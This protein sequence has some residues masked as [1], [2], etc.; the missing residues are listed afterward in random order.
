ML[1]GLRLEEAAMT[2]YLT[3]CLRKIASCLAMTGV[4]FVW[5]R[6]TPIVL[7]AWVQEVA[8]RARNDN[9]IW[10]RVCVFYVSPIATWCCNVRRNDAG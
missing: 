2:G 8:G 10:L 9:S 5:G 3:V 7:S 1:S 6:V 4:V